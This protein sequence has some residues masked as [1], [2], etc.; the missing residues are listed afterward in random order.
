M[1]N[2]K[3]FI[4]LF[5]LFG[6]LSGC[7]DFLGDNFDPDAVDV[8]PVDQIMPVVLFY[9][10]LEN[11]DHSE[12]GTYLSQCLTTPG[13]SQTGAHAYRSGWEFMGMNR[14]PQ[15]RRHFFDVGANAN[16]LIRFATEENSM[17]YVALTRL[18]RLISVQQT[19]D[20]F[21]DMPLS[22]AY[23][24]SAPKY[25]TQESIYIW[26]EQ[27]AD[28][29][30][31]LFNSPEVIQESNRL[32]SKGIDR[33]FA[34]DMN[35]WLHVVYAI[36]AR[37]LLRHIP[38]IATDAATCNNIIT[39]A[40][41]ALNGWNDPN[42]KFDGGS[43]VEKNCMWGRTNRPVNGWESRSNDLGSAI[44]SKFFVENVLGFNPETGSFND[45]RLPLFMKARGDAAGGIDTTFR[46]LENNSGMPATHKIE[47]YPDMYENVLTSDTS[48]ICL[49]TKG[50]L[51]FIIAE[52]AFWAGDKNKAVDNLIS[53]IRYH[54]GRMG[55]A[56][57][58]IDSYVTNTDLVP[59]SSN[60]T[61]S[62]IMIEKY[63][64]MYLQPEQWNDLR[65]YGYSNDNNNIQYDNSIV[66]PGLRRPHNL[67][68]AYWSVENQWI[69]RLNY[70]PETEEK[71]NRAELE[72]LGAYRNPEW[73]K[74]PM[75]WGHQN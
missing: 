21:G 4:L 68:E 16:N 36:K 6:L 27:E 23:K 25:D 26:M 49:L 71:Y 50:E 44:P 73:L 67:Y 69:Q 75:I 30:I 11:Y 66:Y 39:T 46:Y 1:E 48:T 8:V 74:K 33:V 51:H 60:I 19:T 31:E 10:V 34:G 9:S 42:Y 28:D 58:D 41:T 12:Y 57:E 54:M 70:D 29:L 45:P 38:N 56:T 52:A 24:S 72:R 37:I 61:L 14:H 43:S 35:A 13:Q 63:K 20:V 15:W 40:E 22:D 3:K 55:V 53:G 59:G 65:R 5:V 64:A 62:N 2:I 18:L 47:W 17:N 32:M 7:D